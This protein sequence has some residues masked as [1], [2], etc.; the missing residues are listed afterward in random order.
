MIAVLNWIHRPIFINNFKTEKHFTTR[1][2]FVH[3]FESTQ[4]LH[5][6]RYEYLLTQYTTSR[7]PRSIDPRVDL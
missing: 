4:R 2:T 3:Q 7:P 1:T 5:S 6:T